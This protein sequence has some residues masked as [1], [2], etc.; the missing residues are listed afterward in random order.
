[1][2]FKVNQ[3]NQLESVFKKIAEDIGTVRLTM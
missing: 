1:M 2:Y 3:A